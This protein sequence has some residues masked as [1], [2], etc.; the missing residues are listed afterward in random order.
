MMPATIARAASAGEAFSSVSTSDIFVSIGPGYT[1]NT[2]VFCPRSIARVTC[3]SECVAAFQA[4]YAARMG[5]LTND[6]TELRLATAPP[7]FF[8][9]TGAKA[10]VTAK[11]PRKFTSILS[12][13]LDPLGIGEIAAVETDDA[14]VV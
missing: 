3:V 14:G 2:C 13:S 7:S 10:C 8:A 9:R 5:K 11:V 4:L 6:A 12:A 1:P